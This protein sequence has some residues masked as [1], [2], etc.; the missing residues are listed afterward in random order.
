M[1]A[2]LPGTN[3][4]L[5]LLFFGISLLDAFSAREWLRAAFWLM[6]GLVFLWADMPKRNVKRVDERK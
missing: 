3:I 1:R 4:T 2:Q 6:I 5:F